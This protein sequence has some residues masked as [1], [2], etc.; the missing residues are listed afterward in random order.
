MKSFK[1]I[2]F[3]F[4]KIALITQFFCDF[5]SKLAQSFYNLV[6]IYFVPNSVLGS[7][8]GN[9]DLEWMMQ[10]LVLSCDL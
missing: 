5:V 7:G 2:F 1:V 10:H 6:S 8:S 3:S 9:T 4:G